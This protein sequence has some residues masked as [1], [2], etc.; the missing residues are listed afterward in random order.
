M[1]KALGH[2]HSTTNKQ[3]VEVFQN[4]EKYITKAEV[5]NRVMLTIAEIKKVT[6][7]KKC[8]IAWSGGKDSLVVGYLAGQAGITQGVFAHTDLEYPAFMEWV[9]RHK[10]DEI[11]AVNSGHDID[12]VK[13]HPQFLFP[14]TAALHGRWYSMVQQATVNR[15]FHRESLDL[16][17]MGRR[18][19]DGNCVRKNIYTNANNVTIY[20]CIADWENEL[21]LGFLHYYNIPIPPIYFWENGFIE[22]THPWSTRNPVDRSDMTAWQEI[23]NIDSSVVLNAAL[24]FDSAKQFLKKRGVSS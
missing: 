15:Y 4:I 17:L 20:N 18:R 22:G 10:P 6:R 8:A 23:F 13:R 12:W 11:E 14:K 24:H 3:W 5:D 19:S 21:I 16:V 2:K 9:D 1:I 7:G